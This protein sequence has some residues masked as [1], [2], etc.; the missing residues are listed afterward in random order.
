MAHTSKLITVI[1]ILLLIACGK[2]IGKSTLAAQEL[3]SVFSSTRP[4][5][6]LTQGKWIKITTTTEGVYK[7]SA[8]KLKEA[9]FSNPNDIRIYG[10]GGR[11]LPERLSLIAPPYMT[12]QSTWVHNGEVYFFA[13]GMVN[14]FFDS[15]LQGYAPET[16]LYSLKGYYLVT[17]NPSL[18]PMGL[19]DGYAYT[20][21]PNSTITTY[22]ATFVH[23]VDRVSLKKSGRIL[24]GE[25]LSAQTKTPIIFNLP[26][27]PA[28][29]EARISFA[30]I[31]HPG[32]NKKIPVIISSGSS[33]VTDEIL[34]KEDYTSSNYLA[35]IYHRRS[36]P[37]QINSGTQVRLEASLGA[38]A[39]SS[40]LDYM[41]LTVQLPLSYKA[42]KQ[43]IFTKALENLPQTAATYVIA[44]ASPE[45]RIWRIEEANGVAD[46][47]YK[48]ISGGLS[49][50]ALVST[51]NAQPTCFVYFK[52]SDAYEVQEMVTLSNQPDFASMEVPDYVI[53]TTETLREEAERLAEHHRTNNHLKTIVVSQQ[54]VFNRF[55]QGTP[56][57]TAY[58]LMMRYFFDRSEDPG[59][60]PLLLLFGDGVYDNRK[61]SDDFK[62]PELQKTEMLLTYQ[63]YN[64]TNVYSYTSDDYFGCLDPADDDKTL[65]SKKLSVGIGRLP[66][67]TLKEAKQ[68]VNKIIDYDLNKEPGKWKSRALFVA[69]NQDGYS[70]LT[71][72][73]FQCQTLEEVMPALNAT[74]V[75]MDAFP[76]ETQNGRTS[77]P[78]AKKKLMDEL[79][80]GLL[81]LNYTGHGGPAAWTDE[82]ILTMTDVLNAN[83][84]NLPVWITATCDFTNFDHPTTSAGEEAMLHP[85]SGA[86]ALFTTTRVVMDLDNKAMHAQLIKHLFAQQKDGHLNPLGHVMCFSKNAMNKGDTINKLNFLLIGDPAIR[87]KMP[88]LTAE[89]TAIDGA[90]L[91]NQSFVSLQAMQKVLMEGAVVDA[92]RS[93]QGNFDGTM[94]ITIYDARQK[95][96]PH[97]D[98]ASK[99]GT[100]I[101][102]YDYP[103]AIY[104]NS[105]PVKGGRF[106]FEFVVPKDIAY[107]SEN[108][109]ISLYAFSDSK[110]E[111]IGIERSIRIVPGVPNNPVTDTIAPKIESFFLGH[112]GFQ[113]GDAVGETPLFVAEISDES[114]LNLGGGGIGHD[115]T[116]TIDERRD[117]SFVL[118]NHYSASVDKANTGIVQY[119]LPRLE[120]GNHTATLT[121]WDVC[122]NS[123]THNFDFRVRAG[124]TS[125]ILRATVYPTPA[126]EG[127]AIYFD[128]YNNTPKE[129]VDVVIELFDLGGHRVAR[130]ATQRTRSQ[131]QEP[132][133][134]E[135]T[136]QT[137]YGT[138]VAPGIYTYRIVATYPNSLPFVYSNKLVIVR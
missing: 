119:M 51:A 38:Q 41:A 77:S 36:Y 22:D 39:R 97:P 112:T 134:I 74:K 131:W 135:W 103:G 95:V 60:H 125:K 30:H 108:G 69:D 43:L 61:I 132:A 98:N 35:G 6:S 11:M 114:G 3:P 14:V 88:H 84:K 130:S 96:Q 87:L 20:A 12:Q 42:G 33:E 133:R 90:E 81:L 57:A 127:E 107:A 100:Q 106:S 13:H 64:S 63:G 4:S 15:K 115:I 48:Q 105:V 18:P 110:N 73:E 94:Y 25:P 120:E 99:Y 37:L 93:V 56:D 86:A 89:I 138:A 62:A 55:S 47:P 75:Y 113:P 1:S 7:L 83:Y 29:P 19:Q 102:F 21:S 17:E 101:S 116:L 129:E 53:L 31:T 34:D 70:H 111:A 76:L 8:K 16:H 79:D 91:P 5:P 92:D 117:L 126:K 82:Q 54:E 24:F 118:N 32:N 66:L 27:K 137:S 49:F 23:E 123:T 46:M 28:K 40:Y 78:A 128:L 68:V 122:N 71:Q 67:R 50:E 136:P 45:G 10:Q 26:D 44:G 2:V 9:G 65:G 104:N 52:P 80:K 121:V 59:Y 109:K 85:H 58:R 124:Q 72:A